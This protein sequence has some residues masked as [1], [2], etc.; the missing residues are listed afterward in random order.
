M[1]VGEISGEWSEKQSLLCSS[2]PN[3][4]NT[5]S[6]YGIDVDRLYRNR[7]HFIVIVIKQTR[8]KNR[9]TALSAFEGVEERDR[10]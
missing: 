5:R 6:K 7:F 9:L 1:R 4:L 2:H 10:E 3:I 8:T